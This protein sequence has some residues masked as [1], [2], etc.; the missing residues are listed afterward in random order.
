MASVKIS[1]DPM[2]SDA[3]NHLKNEMETKFKEMYNTD[4][5]V[6]IVDASKVLGYKYFRKNYGKV[7]LKDVE[8]LIGSSKGAKRR[9]LDKSVRRSV[10]GNRKDRDTG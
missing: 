9:R 6:S 10:N 4:I 1:I 2:C 3:I 5:N 7:S 8:M